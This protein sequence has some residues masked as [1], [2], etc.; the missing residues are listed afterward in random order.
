MSQINPPY[1]G[2]APCPACQQDVRNVSALLHNTFTRWPEGKAFVRL[3]ELRHTPIPSELTV[4]HPVAQ[5]LM[6]VARALVAACDGMTEEGLTIRW[7]PDVTER[8]AALADRA[9]AALDAF[10]PLANAHFHDARHCS[11]ER[12][13]LRPSRGSHWAGFVAPDY[14]AAQY[15]YTVDVVPD[16]GD[17]VHTVCGTHLRLH[18]HFLQDLRRDPAFFGKVRCPTCRLDAPIAQFAIGAKQ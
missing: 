13:M 4:P 5:E 9:K 3:N 8:V 16:G 2:S 12:N 10:A 6:D 17:I 18:E 14:Q 15:D 7:T 1:D 11:G